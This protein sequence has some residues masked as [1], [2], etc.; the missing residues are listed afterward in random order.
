MRRGQGDG[1]WEPSALELGV[2]LGKAQRKNKAL[3]AQVKQLQEQL[4]SRQEP[5]ARPPTPPPRS[6]GPLWTSPATG[7][8]A[9]PPPGSAVY[10]GGSLWV[11]WEA[12]RTRFETRETERAKQ[13]N[14]GR[15]KAVRKACGWKAGE[16]DPV[17]FRAAKGF[18]QGTDTHGAAGDGTV[19]GTHYVSY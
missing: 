11:G 13:E 1:D 5:P 12:N 10:C 6:P 4:K 7:D 9:P 2:K 19:A 17:L 8:P 16:E 3:E 14:Y 15:S 18:W